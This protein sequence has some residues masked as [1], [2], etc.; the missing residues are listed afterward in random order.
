MKSWKTTL[1]G[2]LSGLAILIGGAIQQKQADPKAPPVTFGNIA[3]AIAVSLLGYF[4]KDHDV[5]GGGK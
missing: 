3:P 4:A 2:I 1:L 5:T